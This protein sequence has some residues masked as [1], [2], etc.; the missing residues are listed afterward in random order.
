MEIGFVFVMHPR[1]KAGL[2]LTIEL[3]QMSQRGQ[4]HSIHI[5][6]PILSSL[7]LIISF[8]S[9][10]ILLYLYIYVCERC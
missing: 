10:L 4:P 3:E 1:V 5:L 8:P 2:K 6:F 7:L 9:L